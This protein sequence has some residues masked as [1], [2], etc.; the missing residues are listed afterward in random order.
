MRDA[1]TACGHLAQ[2]VVGQLPAMGIEGIRP[3]EADL[4]AVIHR[5][6]AV[7]VLDDRAFALADMG[8]HTHPAITR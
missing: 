8:M 6:H 7:T 2:L 1:G 5:P 4:R 3:A